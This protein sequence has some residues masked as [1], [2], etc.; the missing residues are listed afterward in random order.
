VWQ[1]EFGVKNVAEKLVNIKWTDRARDD[2]CY[3]DIK[4]LL[5]EYLDEATDP[6]ISFQLALTLKSN[7]SPT[8]K[9][10]LPCLYSEYLVRLL[11]LLLEDLLEC[12]ET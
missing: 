10:L 12:L 6:L 11:L 2:R 3:K 1:W 5:I 4:I 8:A 9:S 7:G